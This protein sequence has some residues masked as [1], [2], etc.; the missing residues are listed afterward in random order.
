MRPYATYPSQHD[1]IQANTSPVLIDVDVENLKM[2]ESLG[3]ES[4]SVKKT[5][6]RRQSLLII[7]I[8]LE[9]DQLR[10]KR[11]LNTKIYPHVMELGQSSTLTFLK[12]MKQLS[13]QTL[14]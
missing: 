8:S 4:L 6:F 14:I 5:F 11:I 9:M 1:N 2:D 7:W 10:R 12:P 13:I 3:L